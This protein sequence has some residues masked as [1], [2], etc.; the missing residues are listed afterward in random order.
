VAL[1]ERG[2]PWV[3]WAWAAGGLWIA[4][5]AAL[6]VAGIFPSWVAI[7]YAVA[8]LIAFATYAV[9]KGQAGAEGPRVSERALHALEAIGGWPGALVAQRQF[10]HKTR[11]P[12]FQLIFWLIVTAHLGTA[13][14]WLFFRSGGD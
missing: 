13:A 1:N 3:G 8:S 2:S 4:G 10:R 12:R 7:W 14:A 6:A 9:D 11:K 5:T